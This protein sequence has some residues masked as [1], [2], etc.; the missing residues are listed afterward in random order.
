MKTL[1][2]SQDNVQVPKLSNASLATKI[3]IILFYI[4]PKTRVWP[5]AFGL[6]YLISE[7]LRRE[8]HFTCSVVYNNH[9]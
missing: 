8:Y 4:K 2:F 7:N 5:L 9:I 1:R 3:Q 6:W